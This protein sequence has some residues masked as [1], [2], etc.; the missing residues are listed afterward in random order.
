MRAP[1]IVALAIA[2]V[3]L[4]ILGGVTVRNDLRTG[5][6][7]DHMLAE[8][9]DRT[10]ELNRVTR[11]TSDGETCY[12][13][14]LAVLATELSVSKVREHFRGVGVSG[15]AW[16]AR[17]GFLATSSDG[18]TIDPPERA[19]AILRQWAFLPSGVRRVVVFSDVP[20]RGRFD[21]RCF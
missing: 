11:V 16:S 17:A 7:F 14:A 2:T 8:L 1:W 18:R 9:P 10:A 13:R 21:V 3:S 12:G 6:K 15:I 20:V 19:V 5:Q 4:G